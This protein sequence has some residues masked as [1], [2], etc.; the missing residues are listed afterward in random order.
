MLKTYG[1]LMGD[2]CCSLLPLRS[3]LVLVTAWGGQ[4]TFPKI[5]SLPKPTLI[6]LGK[7]KMHFNM[8][9]SHLAG[10]RAGFTMS[11]KV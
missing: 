10:S 9:C 11:M 6:L 1:E 4:T 7:K 3:W 5:D 8:F 2:V